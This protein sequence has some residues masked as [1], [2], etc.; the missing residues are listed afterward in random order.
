MEIWKDITSFHSVGRCVEK[1][2]LSESDVRDFLQFCTELVYCDKI[3]V[4]LHGP[5]YMSEKTR[6]ISNKLIRL[7]V[8]KEFICLYSYPEINSIKTTC[9]EISKGLLP[10]IELMDLSPDVFC[11]AHDAVFPD[12]YVERLSDTIS[13]FKE[14]ILCGKNTGDYS[15]SIEESLNDDKLNIILYILLNDERIR[16]LLQCKMGSQNWT[17]ENILCLIANFRVAL[18]QALSSQQELIYAPSYARALNNRTSLKNYVKILNRWLDSFATDIKSKLD[19]HLMSDLSVPSVVKFYLL[20]DDLQPE[21]VISLALDMRNSLDWLRKTILCNIN[22]ILF[23]QKDENSFFE[24]QNELKK[25]ER[26]I[27]SSIGHNNIAHEVCSAFSIDSGLNF[28]LSGA[29]I[30]CGSIALKKIFTNANYSLFTR[31]A[32][33]ACVADKE[34]LDL[35]IRMLYNNCSSKKYS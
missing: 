17:D 28:S 1:R 12:N 23:D 21:K 32:K 34:E 31:L 20:T 11:P 3:H 6:S 15:S 2:A 33:V 13:I 22:S 9:S 29:A 19:C 24:M 25:C 14:V 7:G 4:S 27:I 35:K 10:Y 16:Q 8:S 18:N 5:E 26:E 30:K